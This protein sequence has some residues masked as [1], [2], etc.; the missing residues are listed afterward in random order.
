VIGDGMRKEKKNEVKKKKAVPCPFPV[1]D[2]PGGLSRKS[3]SKSLEH[4]PLMKGR[5]EVQKREKGVNNLWKKK[6]HH[7]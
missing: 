6:R 2:R 3:K 1:G 7:C 4:Q 5:E